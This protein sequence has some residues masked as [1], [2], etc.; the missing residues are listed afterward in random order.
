MSRH[1]LVIFSMIFLR[2][3]LWPFAA[4]RKMARDGRKAQRCIR[5]RRSRLAESTVGVTL[6]QSD[7]RTV[8]SEEQ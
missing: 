6:A 4:G 2:Q 5:L 3:E 8:E 7:A 1:A